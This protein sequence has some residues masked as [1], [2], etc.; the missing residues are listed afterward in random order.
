MRMTTMGWLIVAFGAA[1]ATASQHAATT[2]APASASP[3]AR[4]SGRER[5]SAEQLSSTATANVFD[6]L[7]TLKPEILNGR[8]RGEPDVYVGTVK[9]QT[10][11]NRLKELSLV[12]VSEV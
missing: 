5:F 1:C 9:Q 4:T 12:A 11:L 2:S 10:G 6:A 7:T 3:T 8:G